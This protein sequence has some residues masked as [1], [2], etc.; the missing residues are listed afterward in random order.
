MTLYPRIKLVSVFQVYIYDTYAFMHKS[1]T[2]ARRFFFRSWQWQWCV[3]LSENR[4]AGSGKTLLLLCNTTFP[5]GNFFPAIC[6][7]LIPLY[8]YFLHKYDF[9]DRTRPV[10]RSGVMKLFSLNRG[11]HSKTARC[12]SNFWYF[13]QF[14]RFPQGLTKLVLVYSRDRQEVDAFR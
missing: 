8:M 11:N 10:D 2:I 12:C 7:S 14:F 3:V 1:K 6:K 4:G 9:S 5:H 13:E